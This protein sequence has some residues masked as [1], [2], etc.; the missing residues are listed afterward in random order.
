MAEEADTALDFLK[1]PP[2]IILL[3]TIVE[4]IFT[5]RREKSFGVS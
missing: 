4:S 2:E 1:V 3:S 5:S